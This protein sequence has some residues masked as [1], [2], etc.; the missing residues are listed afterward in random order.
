MTRYRA[1]IPVL[2]V[3]AIFFLNACEKAKQ[4]QPAPKQPA[5]QQELLIGLIPEQNVFRQRERYMVIRKYLSNR[6]GITVNFTSLSR[7]GNII[8]RFNAEKMDGAFF[9]SFTYALAHSQLGVE[10]IARPVNLDGTSTYHG[11]IFVR[12]D[13]GIRTARDMKGKR[14]AFVEHAT[15][16]G[17]LFPLAYFRESGI[18]DIQSYVG[19]VFFTGSHDTAV[20]AVLNREADIGSAKNTI[21][22]QMAAENPRVA[23]ELVILAASGVVPQNGLAVRKDLDPDL[24][25]ALKR[26]LLDMDK[27][28]EGIE[29]LRRFGARGFI[30]TSTKDY[31][32]LYRLAERV[33]IDFKTYNYENR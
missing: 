26:T 29:A 20:L 14:F 21:Y 24:K 32:Y 23:K 17:Y 9:G 1:T 5:A 25:N 22:D 31:E 6:L 13:S 7:Y 11:C 8:E 19:E 28:S 4:Q 27:D 33:G 16:A 3:A 12:K 15:T 2:I 10:A 18:T 30:E